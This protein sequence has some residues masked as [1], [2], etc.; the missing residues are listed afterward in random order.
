ML[1]AGPSAWPTSSVYVAFALD[2]QGGGKSI[3]NREEMMERIGAFYG[4]P[5]RT[6]DIGMAGLEILLQE[7]RTDP[8]D[9]HPSGTASAAPW[10]SSWRAARPT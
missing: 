10:P 7:P 9:W 5:L 1:G 8:S 6:R 4:D 3:E 2:Y